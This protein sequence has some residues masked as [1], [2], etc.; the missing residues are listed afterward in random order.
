MTAEPDATSI[1]NLIEKLLTVRKED[2]L[3]LTRVTIELDDKLLD[4]RFC[5]YLMLMLAEAAVNQAVAT[6]GVESGEVLEINA[7]DADDDDQV[8]FELFAH[9]AA[10]RDEQAST[11][12]VVIGADTIIRNVSVI[13]AQVEL[14]HNLFEGGLPIMKED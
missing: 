9:T 14:L 13:A 11:L 10:N 3:T 12:S 6:S 2:Y 8:A 4:R 7:V 1:A 5:S